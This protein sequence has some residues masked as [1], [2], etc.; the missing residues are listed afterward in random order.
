MHQGSVGSVARAA[1]AVVLLHPPLEGSDSSGQ[2]G[3]TYASNRDGTC[4]VSDT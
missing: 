1:A 3:A 2:R 4:R